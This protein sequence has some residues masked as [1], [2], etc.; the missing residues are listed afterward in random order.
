MAWG[1]IEPEPQVEEWLRALDDEDYGQVARYIDLLADEGVH[2]GEPFTRQ[3][4]LTHD[5]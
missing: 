5:A 3:R 4:R 1:T 2:L